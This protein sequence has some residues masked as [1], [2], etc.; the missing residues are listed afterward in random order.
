M[1]RFHRPEARPARAASRIRPGSIP[2]RW[3]GRVAASAVVLFLAW[4]AY[5]YLA[6]VVIEALTG[7]FFVLYVVLVGA[8][9]GYV[10]WRLWHPASSR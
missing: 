4:L 3:P 7:P 2:R 5:A 10:L 1:D 8:S 6:P 9:A